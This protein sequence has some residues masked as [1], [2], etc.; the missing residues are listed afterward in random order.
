MVCTGK[1]LA[2]QGTAREGAV[3]GA[4]GRSYYEQAI[5]MDRLARD[6]RLAD[7][8]A[9]RYRRAQRIREVNSRRPEKEQADG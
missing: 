2:I 8:N 5:I 6:A 1:K 7:E 9:P 4:D 3:M